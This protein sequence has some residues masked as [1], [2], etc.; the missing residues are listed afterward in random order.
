MYLR[1]RETTKRAL[2]RW[3]LSFENDYSEIADETAESELKHNMNYEIW[4]SIKLTG[5][6][7]NAATSLP[8]DVSKASFSTIF[9]SQA[10][11]WQ[12]RRRSLYI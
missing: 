8:L 11:L 3:Y 1:E 9:E 4:R 10:Q 6:R 7:M 2:Q 12:K 5:N